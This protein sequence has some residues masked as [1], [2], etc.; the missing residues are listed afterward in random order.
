MTLVYGLDGR[1]YDIDEAS[2]AKRQLSNEQLGSLMQRDD[3]PEGLPPGQM[4]PREHEFPIPE[5]MRGLVRA[6][7]FE[8]GRLVIDI[9]VGALL[10]RG[11]P[12][13]PPPGPAQGQGNCGPSA[14]GPN[15]GACDVS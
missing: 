9:N 3:L 1:A 5:E 15:P 13:G 6:R 10:G 14:C 4:P 12:S 7:A 2:L 8:D 11:G